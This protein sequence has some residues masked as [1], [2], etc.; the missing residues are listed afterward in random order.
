MFAFTRAHRD[1]SY[2]PDT[3]TMGPAAAN[4][5]G[6]RKCQ[7]KYG[8]ARLAHMVLIRDGSSEHGV[9]RCSEIQVFRFA[10]GIRSHFDVVKSDFFISKKTN[11]TSY[12]RNMF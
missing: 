8:A 11:F 6:I 5:S 10:E 2:P 7:R 9:R 4:P 3:R 1:L 12:V